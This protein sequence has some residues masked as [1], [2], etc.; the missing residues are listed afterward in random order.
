MTG[1]SSR[2][3]RT[4]VDAIPTPIQSIMFARQCEA[5]KT[6]NFTAGGMEFDGHFVWHRSS[7]P[8]VRLGS[9][10]EITRSHRDVRFAP[11]GS[12]GQ[13]NT[14]CSLSAGVSNP[15]VLRGR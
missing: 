1:L 4:R 14:A 12:T 2:H 13:C 11:A 15:K 9:Q 10:A 7:E 8:N 5:D 6:P 3:A